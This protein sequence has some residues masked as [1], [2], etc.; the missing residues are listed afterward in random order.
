MKWECFIAIIALKLLHWPQ[1]LH[2]PVF[3]CFQVSTGV[4]AIVVCG[5]S[6]QHRTARRR[7]TV[8][9]LLI[10][11]S[12]TVTTLPYQT[13]IYVVTFMGKQSIA[14]NL[15]NP[16]RTAA[17]LNACLHPVIFGLMWR[18]FQQSL[19]QVILSPTCWQTILSAKQFIHVQHVVS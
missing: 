1:L 2:S 4:T 8:M 5:L 7:V 16:L 9:C 14:A 19:L 15:I 13:V 17:M 12:F 11:V 18:P 6:E 3:V 10:A